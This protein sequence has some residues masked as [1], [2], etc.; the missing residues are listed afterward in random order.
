VFICINGERALNFNF[1]FELA[2]KGIIFE[3]FIFNIIV[4]N[5]YFERK[6]GIFIMKV[7]IIRIAANLFNIL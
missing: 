6:E 1:K 7:R 5:D 4:Q 3:T 2:V